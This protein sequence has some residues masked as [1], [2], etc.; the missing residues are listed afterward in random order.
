MPDP[1]PPNQP[2]TVV[3]W[4]NADKRLH[5]AH[6]WFWGVW[7][8]SG[9]PDYSWNQ[10]PP[11]ESGFCKTKSEARKAATLNR[12]DFL[13]RNWWAE[14]YL[15]SRQKQLPLFSTIRSGRKWFWCVGKD[16]ID[17]PDHTGFSTSAAAALDTAVQAAGSDV[18][19][20]GN[21]MAR[22]ALRHLRAEKIRER[23]AHSPPPP[24]YAQDPKSIAECY[25]TLGIP[26]GSSVAEVKNAYRKLALI[27]HPDL[28][29]NPQEFIRIHRLY[30]Q[31]LAR[32]IC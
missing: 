20:T 29:G 1:S 9:I 30:E 5:G 4:T 3:S 10:T 26:P 18:Q 25:K 17:D 11:L 6:H 32:A 24:R 13:Q 28:G 22:I 23:Q 19:R 2:T 8:V 31:A 14:Q 7:Q 12:P 27:H 16:L 21:W 15:E